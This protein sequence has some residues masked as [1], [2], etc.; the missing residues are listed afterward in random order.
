MCSLLPEETE[1][2]AGGPYVQASS[3]KAL[4][5]RSVTT[6]THA[7]IV[8]DEDSPRG[9]AILMLLKMSASQNLT[10]GAIASASQYSRKRAYPKALVTSRAANQIFF[11]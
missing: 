8:F 11:N 5:R 10:L 9:V 4:T 3:N 1:G 6:S 7:I 2:R